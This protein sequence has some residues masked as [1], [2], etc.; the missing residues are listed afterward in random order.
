MNDDA[1][2]DGINE[3]EPLEE[4]SKD[5]QLEP[6][7]VLSRGIEAPKPSIEEPPELELKSLPDHLKYAYLG[8]LLPRQPIA[9]AVDDSSCARIPTQGC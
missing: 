8:N 4:V 3:E 5:K 6:L 7:E 9:V 2:K 1:S